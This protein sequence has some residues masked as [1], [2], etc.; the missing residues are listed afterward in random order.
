MNRSLNEYALA[1]TVV[2]I[3]A[4]VAQLVELPMHRSVSLY[5]GLM[6]WEAPCLL[7]APA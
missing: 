5:P 2:L 3:Y 6:L 7:Q 1:L 4:L